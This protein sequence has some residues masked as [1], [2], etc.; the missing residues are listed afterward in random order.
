MVTWYPGNG[1]RY[2]KHTDNN[3]KFGDGNSCNGRRLTALTYLN[4]EW[5]TGDMVNYVYMDDAEK[6]KAEVAPVAGRILLFGPILEYHM[7]YYHI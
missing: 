4:D 6:I 1:A 7:K 3:C 5:K 2:I